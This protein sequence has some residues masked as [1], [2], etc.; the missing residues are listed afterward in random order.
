MFVIQNRHSSW[1]ATT[2]GGMVRMYLIRWDNIVLYRKKKSDLMMRLCINYGTRIY[3]TYLTLHW[4]SPAHS[5]ILKLNDD[6][7]LCVF[8]SQI[9]L[10]N[11][12]IL[13]LGWLVNFCRIGCTNLIILNCFKCFNVFSLLNIQKYCILMSYSR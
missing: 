8:T 3:V 11:I 10:I 13:R 12:I 6:V 2:A 1:E 4:I 9:S 7:H 5:Q